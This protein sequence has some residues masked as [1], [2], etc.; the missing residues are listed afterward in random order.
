MEHLPGNV[1]TTLADDAA[2]VANLAGL[3]LDEWQ[4]RVLE[5]AMAIRADGKWAAFQVGYEVPRQNGKS[6][7]V[8]ARILAGLFAMSHERTIVYS[9]HEFKTAVQIF[10]RLCRLIEEMPLLAAE[11]KQIRNGNDGREI[12]LKDGSSVKFLAR[13]GTSVRGFTGDLVILD[14]AFN[15]SSEMIAAMLPTMAA[16]SIE[17]NPQIWYLSS[18]GAL[19][20]TVLNGLRESGIAEDAPANL[21]WMEWS[22]DA[23]VDSEDRDAWYQANPALGLRISE[24]FIADE[25]TA[26]R[27]DPELGEA[28]WRR[29]RL[30]V[31]EARITDTVIPAKS[32][33]ACERDDFKAPGGDHSVAFGVDVPPERDSAWIA[34]AWDLNDGRVFVELVDAREGTSWVPS[35][36]KGLRDR[37]DPRSIVVDGKGA[38]SAL[39]PDIKAEGVPTRS[40]SVQDLGAACARVWDLI[41]RGL[42]VHNGQQDLTDA[43]LNARTKPL[44]DSGLWKWDRRNP[45]AQISP[46]IAVSL[47]LHGL[48]GRKKLGA[49][50]RPAGRVVVL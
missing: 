16:R 14:E 8:E 41:D 19:G 3:F 17:G 2:A 34:A 38:A 9:A 43:A 11:V 24:E 23:S 33:K 49:P 39:L 12:L 44:G 10:N 42:L 50:R 40:P 29:E 28:K 5:Q 30:G 4:E 7:V 13:S 27:N 36:F 21:L 46:L 15:L 47:A 35:R 48:T 1:L 26:F 25:L 37:W 31:R 18:A 32:W 6:A 45:V 22:A 20:S